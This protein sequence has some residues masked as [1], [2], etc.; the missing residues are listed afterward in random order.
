M[1]AIPVLL[2]ELSGKEPQLKFAHPAGGGGGAWILVRTKPGTS[3]EQTGIGGYEKY[4]GYE[5]HIRLYQVRTNR[6]NRLHILASNNLSSNVL[7]TKAG[8]KCSSRRVR[9]VKGLLFPRN[10]HQHP[11]A[12]GRLG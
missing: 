9:E 1:A 2:A 6:E 10:C 7:V 8:Q 12:I 4:E 3:P 11:S 5:N